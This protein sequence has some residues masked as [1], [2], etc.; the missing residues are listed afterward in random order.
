VRTEYNLVCSAHNLKRILINF[1]F[2][3]LMI[4]IA[5]ILGFR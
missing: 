2:K 5:H 3:N 4:P 1:F